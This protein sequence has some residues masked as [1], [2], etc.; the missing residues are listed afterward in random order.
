MDPIDEFLSG[1]PCQ[2]QAICQKRRALVKSAIF[3]FL[4]VEVCLTLIE[5]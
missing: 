1:Y 5:I 2:V 4:G 3:A